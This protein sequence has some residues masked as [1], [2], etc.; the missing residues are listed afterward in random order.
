MR[1]YNYSTLIAGKRAFLEAQLEGDDMRWKV[2]LRI[3]DYMPARMQIGYLVGARR[4]W[5]A[6]F[7][8]KARVASECRSAKEACILL[9]EHAATLPSVQGFF[10]RSAS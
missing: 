5:L 1:T 4:R 7:P 3:Q 8:E 6:H 2:Y 9:A 10:P